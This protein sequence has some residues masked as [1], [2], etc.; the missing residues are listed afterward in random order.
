MH[1]LLPKLGVNKNIP[2][3]VVYG[4]RLLGRMEFMNIKVEQP[5]LTIQTKIGH[6]QREDRVDEILYASPSDIQIKMGY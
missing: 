1:L 6:L 2:R 3:A 4:P 5:I